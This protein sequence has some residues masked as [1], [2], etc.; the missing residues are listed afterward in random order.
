LAIG[1]EEEAEKDE[2]DGEKGDGQDKAEKSEEIATDHQADED[3]EGVE[4]EVRAEE[5]GGEVVA[6]DRLDENKDEEQGEELREARAV[7]GEKGEGESETREGAKVGDKVKEAGENAKSEVERDLEKEEADGIEKAHGKGNQK[8]VTD[9]GRKDDIDLMEEQARTGPVAGRDELV[10]VRS[11]GPTV[12]QQV[13]DKERDQEEI[14]QRGCKVCET[15]E[16]LFGPGESGVAEARLFGR[17]LEARNLGAKLL[18]KSGAGGFDPLQSL[19]NPGVIGEKV[20]SLLVRDAQLV[21]D[22]GENEEEEEPQDQGGSREGG[23][24]GGHSG[25]TTTLD[26]VDK[27]GQ[28]VSDCNRDK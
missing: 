28:E 18:V 11:H 17:I 16:S 14:E 9:K 23:N 24:D 27:W 8:L 22:C 1:S 19:L 13:E 4:I 5:F 20:A 12:D 15:K 2:R 25:I 7:E 21:P 6:F 3:Q 26:P 10:E